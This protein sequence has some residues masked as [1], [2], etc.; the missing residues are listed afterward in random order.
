MKDYGLHEYMQV[1]EN[2]DVLLDMEEVRRVVVMGYS[3]QNPYLYSGNGSGFGEKIDKEKRNKGDRE[4]REKQK[5]IFDDEEEGRTGK[6]VDIESVIEQHDKLEEE[7]RKEAEERIW[8][9]NE[10]LLSGNNV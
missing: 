4:R 9:E 3:G 7:K 6:M 5:Q 2:F 8:K 10:G 1:R